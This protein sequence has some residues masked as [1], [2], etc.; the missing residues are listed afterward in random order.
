MAEKKSVKNKTTKGATIT[1][2]IFRKIKEEIP[3]YRP[4]MTWEEA[5][6][7]LNYGVSTL[8]RINGCTSYREYLEKIE[9]NNLRNMQ[10]VI[11]MPAPLPPPII[12]RQNLLTVEGYENEFAIEKGIPLPTALNRKYPWDQLEIGDSFLV[13]DKTPNLLR[14][15]MKSAEDRFGFAFTAFA[16]KNGTR[17]WRV[18]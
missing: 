8:H 1:E 14:S 15:C 2:E 17:I 16:D 10:T 7:F 9:K 3:K 11:Q 5:S 13:P 12:A 6:H 4:R 18:K